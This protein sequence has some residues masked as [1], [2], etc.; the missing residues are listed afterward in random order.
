[1]TWNRFGSMASLLC[2]LLVGYAWSGCGGIADHDCMENPGYC[3]FNEYCDS[4]TRR[5]VLTCT[6]LPPRKCP[7]GSSCDYATG[8]CRPLCTGLVQDREV[9]CLNGE[10][11]DCDGHPD[12][13]DSECEGLSCG[14]ACQC[15][16][17][18]RRELD[19]GNGIDD[20]FDGALDCA[21]RADCPAGS[22]CLTGSG[23]GGTCQA[24]SCQ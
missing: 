13:A 5:C 15:A 1:M 11:D 19:C 12:C 24:G 16:S 7:E 18:L 17:G 4:D 8:K 20:D 14:E 22:I 21:D 23:D 6:A 9:S 10:D 2:G 3:A